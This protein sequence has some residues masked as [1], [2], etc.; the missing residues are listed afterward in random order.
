MIL[1]NFASISRILGNIFQ[2]W[3]SKLT[4]D[5]LGLQRY[6][7]RKNIWALDFELLGRNIAPLHFKT[8]RVAETALRA[9]WSWLTLDRFP[10]T[11]GI[12][13]SRGDSKLTANGL[14]LQRNGQRSNDRTPGFELLGRNIS[15]LY[16]KTQRV[17]QTA[18]R[19]AWSWPTLA[20]FPWTWGIFFSPW[21]SKLTL[22]GLGLQRN[23]H[24]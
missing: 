12:F 9:S 5:V 16:F 14:G 24:R 11:W 6:G 19:A 1:S 18:L 13:S 10:G 17:A 7:H 21:D 4:P 2:S 23:G 20:R 22:D 8:E 15:P 3:G